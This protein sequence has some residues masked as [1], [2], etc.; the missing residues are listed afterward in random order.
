[1]RI[2]IL[3]AASLVLSMP[4]LALAQPHGQEHTGHSHANHAVRSVAHSHEI[5]KASGLTAAFH[6]SAPAKPVYT[7]PMHPDV[8]AEKAGTC[9]KCKMRLEKQTHHVAVQLTGAN[10]KPL[11]GATVRLVFKDQHGLLQ[12]LNLKGNGYYEGAFH[13]M[14]GK[15]TATAFVKPAG[16]KEAVALTVPYEVK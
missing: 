2:S 16:A 12:G 7:C 3:L 4:A 10:K 14:P 11:Q 1:M 6:F 9:P 13:L 15:Q 5:A 8:T